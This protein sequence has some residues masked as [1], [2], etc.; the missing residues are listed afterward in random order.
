MATITSNATGNWSAG[1]T[2]VGGAVPIDNDTVIIASGHVVTFDVDQSGFANGINGITITGTLKLTRS[3]GT[4]YLKMKAATTISGAGT[5][6]CGTADDIIPFA[7]KHTVTGGAGWYIKGDDGT[8]MTMTVY[9]AEPTYKVVRLIN[10]EIVGATRLEIDTD[11]TQDIWSVGDTVY[12]LRYA[13]SLQ[14]SIETTT[15]TAIGENY[16][17]IASGLTATKTTGSFVVL[18]NRNVKIIIPTVSAIRY[19]TTSKL[20]IAGGEIDFSNVTNGFQNCNVPVSGGFIT[21]ASTFF[22][23]GGITLTGGVIFGRT[24]AAS[25][26]GNTAT[27]VIKDG[28]I[29]N[30]ANLDGSNSTPTKVEGGVFIEGK[31]GTYFVNGGWSVTGGVFYGGDYFA[32]SPGNA[33]N[34]NIYRFHYGFSKTVGAQLTNV[35]F[36]E[37]YNGWDLRFSLVKAFN[38]KFNCAG[39]SWSQKE[40]YGE[41]ID[42]DQVPGAYKAWTKGGVTTKQATIYPPGYTNAMQTVL[43]NASVEG[44]WQ[45]EVTVGAGASV[46]IKSY[47]RKPSS[48]TYLPRVII[49][50][51]ASTDPFAGG[52]GL[53]TFTMTDSIDTWESDLY[54]YT[55]S[56]NMDVTLVIRCQGMNAT[57]DMFSEVAVTPVSSGGGSVKI[58]PL[59]RVGL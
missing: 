33:Y 46:N 3:A 16:I 36:Y 35:I 43:Q 27:T 52:A 11:L 24:S 57:G 48:M 47:L 8:G 20:V 10:D 40:H 30:M 23:N 38:S 37:T 45:K 19:F 2:W 58:I 42:H 17:D 7:A 6:D 53:H 5:F 41:S 56:G 50:N 21:G 13:N 59:G 18:R 29:V 25:T 4:Y 44:Y 31:G 39:Y 22:A 9:A 32:N 26:F 49:F 54:T 12:I 15:I 34:I 28:Y 1:S 14:S 55:N 51:K